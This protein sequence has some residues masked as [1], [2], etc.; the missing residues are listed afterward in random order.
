MIQMNANGIQVE[1]HPLFL[2]MGMM[3]EYQKVPVRCL[4]RVYSLVEAFFI[5]R[6]TLNL[7]KKAAGES[8]EM[9][10]S[11]SPNMKTQRRN[12]ICWFLKPRKK[13]EGYADST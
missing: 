4:H 6:R 3:W 11:K 8:N 2:E 10:F 12:S 5:I 7:F 1:Y 13:E 9:E